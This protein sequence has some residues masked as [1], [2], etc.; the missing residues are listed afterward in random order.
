MLAAAPP[1]GGDGKATWAVQLH[2][3]S[4]LVYYKN[5]SDGAASW[6]NPFD[7]HPFPGLIDPEEREEENLTNR[8]CALDEAPASFG[9]EAKSTLKQLQ[10]WVDANGI[11]VSAAAAVSLRW[12]QFINTAAYLDPPDTLEITIKLSPVQSDQMKTMN[13]KCAATTTVAEGITLAFKKFSSRMGSPLDADGDAAYVFKIAGYNSF[14]LQRNVRILD[15]TY[16]R[17]CLRDKNKVILI[18]RQLSEEEQQKLAFLADVEPAHS[19]STLVDLL[20]EPHQAAEEI[21]R[22]GGQHVNMQKIYDGTVQKESIEAPASE[23]GQAPW[24]GRQSQVAATQSGEESDWVR[25]QAQAIQAAGSDFV[26]KAGW[27]S[28]KGGTRHNWNKRWFVLSGSTLIYYQDD[29]KD[30]KEKGRWNLSGRVVQR[31]PPKS[32]KYQYSF[33]VSAGPGL[34]EESSRSLGGTPA[35]ISRTFYMYATSEEEMKDWMAHIA[36]ASGVSQLENRIDSGD[37]SREAGE[38]SSANKWAFRIKI[39]GVEMAPTTMQFSSF[40]VRCSFSF[41]GQN[42]PANIAAGDAAGPLYSETDSAPFSENVTWNQWLSSPHYDLSALPATTRIKLMLMGMTESGEKVPVAGLSLP[43]YNHDGTMLVGQH[44]AKLWPHESLQIARDPELL[45]PKVERTASILNL[46][47]CVCGA[48]WSDDSG[49]FH[50]ELPRLK[51]PVLSPKESLAQLLTVE[52]SHAA[53]ALEGQPQNKE[54]RDLL[55]KVGSTDPLYR[56]EDAEK[57]LL[58]RT[59]EYCAHYPKLL[60]KFLMAVEWG[61][62][63]AVSTAHDLLTRWQPFDNLVEVIELL[64]VRFGDSV[65]REYAVYTLERMADV[66]LEKY[67]LQLVQVLKYE[68]YHFS[69]LA[70]FLVRRALQNPLVIGT[71][72]YWLLKSEMH[73]DQSYER[74]G[75]I[76]HCYSANC[77]E[78]RYILRDSST[79]ERLLVK[80]ANECVRIKGDEERLGYARRRLDEINKDFPENFQLGNWPHMSFSRVI[81]SRCKVMD[82]KKKPLFLC[83]ENA[84]PLGHPVY[85]IFKTGDDLRQDLMTLQMIKI[86]DSM[87]LQGGL[88]L[89]MK[90]YGCCATGD[91]TGLIEIVPDSATIA[92][93]QKEYGGKVTGAF[94]KSPI[95][96]FLK[97]NALNSQAYEYA[98]ENFIRSCAGYCVATFVLGIGDRHADN[99]MVTKSGN[100]FHIDFGHFLGHFKSKKIMPGVKILR[101]RSPF[102]FDPSMAY[103]MGGTSHKD[104]AQFEEMCCQAYNNLRKNGSLFLN[105]FIQMIPA[106]MPE[107]LDENDIQ[108]LQRQL[109]LENTDAEADTKFKEEIKKALGTTSRQFD[110]MVHNMVH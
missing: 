35:D 30:K 32:T 77:G 43:L 4:G 9:A 39:L 24:R 104:F 72:L 37:L 23:N 67:L 36:A 31:S 76:L 45:N 71:T 102:V 103:V 29:S 28:K 79:V 74:Y 109:F 20:V 41:G 63:E 97:E 25:R 1:A 87:W 54:E 40:L 22:R 16:I 5:T 26:R 44:A 85:I 90:P 59:R 60:P 82:S 110:N 93:I 46:D 47:G 42:I 15:Y 8:L 3:D 19:E 101:E 53:S 57:Q 49:I 75:V 105:L 84:D 78:H 80:V 55:E 92:N 64:D 81:S 13:F 2:P 94:K 17:E 95:A 89:R 34:Q 73:A 58:W 99:I 68:L 62:P 11:R 21:K 12:P 65:V 27:L 7:A 83:F 52:T 66:D 14:L 69:P 96:D 61:N 38:V 106:G 48:N 107:L 18:L 70:R 50:F 100:L 108:Y 51:V 98:R 33:E 6:R 10:R 56:L 86:M 88:D 91:E